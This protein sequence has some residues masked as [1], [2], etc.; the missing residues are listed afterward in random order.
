M[1]TPGKGQVDVWYLP[2]NA[3]GTLVL[4]KAQ[5][6]QGDDPIKR[7]FEEAQVD[8]LELWGTPMNLQFFRSNVPNK[9]KLYLDSPHNPE[10]AIASARTDK[11]ND[12]Y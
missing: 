11:A 5:R 6:G 7:W 4:P 2:R 10:N 9:V 12:T 1:D 8:D 3:N